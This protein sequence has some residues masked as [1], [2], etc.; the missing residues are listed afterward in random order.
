MAPR[1]A[2]LVQR[3]VG[4]VLARDMLLAA[5]VHDARRLYDAGFLLH[6]LPDAELADAVL[7]HARRI[8]ALAPQA[9][10]L[11]KRTFFMLNQP[12]EPVDRAQPAI[13]SIADIL[14]TAY[15]YADSPEHREGIDAFLAKRPPQF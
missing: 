6:V 11:N 12:A 1:E 14:R 8:V 15:S 7:A 9:A 2:A 10:R 13:N 5:G 4:D 3:A